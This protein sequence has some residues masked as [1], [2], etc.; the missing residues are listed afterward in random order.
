M[1]IAS[2]FWTVWLISMKFLRSALRMK[3]KKQQKDPN[4]MMNSTTKVERPIKQSLI[5]AA[6][7]L[8]AFWKLKNKKHVSTKLY[9]II[10]EVFTELQNAGKH[11]ERHSVVIIA[12][13]LHCLF[14]GNK[15]ISPSSADLFSHLN[16]CQVLQ[17]KK[18]I[19]KVDFI[20]YTIHLIYIKM[21]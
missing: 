2:V 8:N 3:K 11:S 12:V 14:N 1:A 13:Y 5:V 10:P 7:C 4:T 9:Y 21:F 16:H 6:I 15:S 19:N 20:I 18:C 17:N